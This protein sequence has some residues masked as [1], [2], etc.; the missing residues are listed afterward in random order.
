[1]QLELFTQETKHIQLKT[2]DSLAK[3]QYTTTSEERKKKN[4]ITAI[5]NPCL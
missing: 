3:L 1:M 2:R 5:M 4:S